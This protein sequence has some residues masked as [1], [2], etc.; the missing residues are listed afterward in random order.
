MPYRSDPDYYKLLGVDPDVGLRDIEA[1][2]WRFARTLRG[3]EMASYNR[4][5]EVLT[6]NE[7]RRQYDAERG[8]SRSTATVMPAPERVSGRQG[9]RWT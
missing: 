8:P 5:Y 1:A 7:R 3:A 9:W 6:N 2:Y 4:A